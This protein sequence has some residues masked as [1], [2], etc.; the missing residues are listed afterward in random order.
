M[1]KHLKYYGRTRTSFSD[2]L[3][4]LAPFTP[5]VPSLLLLASDSEMPALQM[6][7]LKVVSWAQDLLLGLLKVVTTTELYVHIRYT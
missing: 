5:S 7:W 6:F 1:Q 3:S 4:G 2:W